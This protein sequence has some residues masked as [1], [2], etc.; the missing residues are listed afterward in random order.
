MTSKSI[1]DPPRADLLKKMEQH[2]DTYN[3]C[4]RKHI[5]S[6][7]VKKNDLKSLEGKDKEQSALK[8]TLEKINHQVTYSRMI[9]QRI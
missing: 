3:E 2:M 8:A 4:L 1:E 9:S 6:K 5:K 7:K